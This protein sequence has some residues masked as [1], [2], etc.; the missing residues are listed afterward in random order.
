MIASILYFAA[1]GAT[2][3]GGLGAG[4]ILFERGR[5]HAA[6]ASREQDLENLMLLL[7]SEVD[8]VGLRNEAASAGVNPDQVEAG[9]YA[10]RQGAVSLEDV[11]RFLR[12]SER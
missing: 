9:Y 6:R 1:A 4:G 12:G 3:V 5:Q 8:L 11:L 10:L 7:Q 2:A